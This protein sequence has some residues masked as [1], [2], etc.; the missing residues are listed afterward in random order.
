MIP[1]SIP[2]WEKEYGSVS[3]TWATFKKKKIQKKKK[4]I[5]QKIDSNAN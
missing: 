2:S 5:M 4:K 1:D 3:S